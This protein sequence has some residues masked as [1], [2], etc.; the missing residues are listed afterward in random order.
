MTYDRFTLFEAYTNQTLP[1]AERQV[2]EEQLR[3]DSS[4]SAELLDYQRFKHSLDAVKLKEQLEQIHTRLDQRGA[5]D[6]NDRPPQPLKPT[7]R[8]HRQRLVWPMLTVLLLAG[9]IYWFLRP[10]HAEKT[11]MA[12]YQPEPVSRGA[13]TCSPSLMPG[14]QA[15]R[16]SRY[17]Q[18]LQ[19]F[20]Q[21]P[22]QQ[23][24][25]SYYVGL[26]LL[27]LDQ[28]NEA[29][30]SLKTA[31]V[32]TTNEPALIRQKAEWYLALAYLKASQTMEAKQ[33]LTTIVRQP[34]QPFRQ[35]ATNALAT[36]GD[37]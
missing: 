6:Q 11:F 3:T 28:E 22:A 30:T 24:C 12:Y 10:S 26:T 36:L 15:Y 27:A 1:D 17:K 21:L 20:R 35:V 18:A 33:Q 34:E 25:V 32:N 29:I 14:I 8:F 4:L 19:E 23:P 5:L 9:G 2:L 31:T 16:S 13:A 7:Q 37:D